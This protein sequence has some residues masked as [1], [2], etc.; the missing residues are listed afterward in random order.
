MTSRS[1]A[2]FRRLS[3][4]VLASLFARASANAS[5]SLAAFNAFQFLCSCFIPLYT[6]YFTLFNLESN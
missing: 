2:S 4:S 5:A 3:T 1:S 6:L